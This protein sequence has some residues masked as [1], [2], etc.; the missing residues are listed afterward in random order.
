MSH[1][2]FA[3][4]AYFL[5]SISVLIDKFLL[6]KKIP[7]PI[8][9]VFYF[10][11][12]SLIAL[13][14]L[15][16]VPIPAL[17]TIALAS[18]STALWTLA[19]YLMF[20]ALQKGL[21]SRV[22]PIIGALIPLIPLLYYANVE[23]SITIN[24]TWAA[25]ILTLGLFVIILPNLGGKFILKELLL[26]ITSAALFA[27][28]Y[29]VLKQAYLEAPFMSVFA[30]SRLI[31]IPV[32]LIILAFPKTRRLIFQPSSGQE[33]FLS[34]TGV[35]FIAGQICGGTS[36]LLLTFSIALASP[37]LVNSL[38]GTQYIYLFIFGLFLS[39]RY[40][41]IFKEKQNFIN[42]S[43]RILGIILI[44]LG[45]FLLSLSQQIKL[46]PIKLTFGVT[47]SPRYALELNLNPQLTFI[48]M[49]DDLK[50]KKIRFPVYWDE[51]E[52]SPNK[53]DF[54]E[55]DSYLNQ[56]KAKGVEIML[57][58]GYKQPRWPEC[59]EPDW[60]KGL[61]NEKRKEKIINLVL[62][63]VNH[64]KSNPA[65]RVW[66]LENEP[67]LPFGKCSLSP[68]DRASLLETE[69]SIIRQIDSRPVMIT[70]SGELSSW[71]RAMK[72]GDFF[73][74]TMYRQVWNPILGVVDYPLFPLYYQI[75][76]QIMKSLVA[77][78]SKET[79]IAELQMEPWPA[80]G[81]SLDQISAQKQAE[82]LPLNKFKANIQ[83]AKESNLSE[84]YLWGSEWW[85]LMEEKGYPEYLEYIRGIVK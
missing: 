54:S 67:F 37:A 20:K 8:V 13:I 76:S 71:R 73:G 77:Q 84:A 79:I 52:K 36:E 3:L 15:P 69:L 21:A 40:P 48:R 70:D 85:Y 35:L 19:A 78:T 31:L 33:N 46:N 27:L 58:L 24:E 47:F 32:G 56:A 45:I 44:C 17:R 41:Q 9:Y 30:Y 59:F 74:I 34:K 64:F 49:L 18:T 39:K 14:L 81:E 2:P 66:Q 65:I 63:E 23:H 38:Q 43:A 42:L 25:G 16:F 10:S 22:I 80:K 12:F 29:I 68:K 83:F 75:K 61:D 62:N 53:Y 7:D 26:E 11:A 55:I 28:S 51:V 82:Y 6:T 50:I 57:V 72:L 1:L 60:S 4:L 5:N